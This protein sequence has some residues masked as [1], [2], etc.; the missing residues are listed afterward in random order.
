MD[1]NVC[2][3]GQQVLRAEPREDARRQID[4]LRE[5]QMCL[6]PGKPCLLEA[7]LRIDA[8]HQ[9]IGLGLE[10]IAEAPELVTI[11]RC[12]KA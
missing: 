8:T 3:A 2:G 5:L 1:L 6:V 10:T 12:L 4:A 11:G 7:D 9:H